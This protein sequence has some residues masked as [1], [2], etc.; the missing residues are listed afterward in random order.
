MYLV[1][2]LLSRAAVPVQSY[3]T[4]LR[5]NARAA[6]STARAKSQ[7]RS[8]PNNDENTEKTCA[9]SKS[10]GFA[11]AFEGSF[12]TVNDKRTSQFIADF[13]QSPRDLGP[14]C[15]TLG[16][17]SSFLGAVR[18]SV[19][20]SRCHIILTDHARRNHVPHASRCQSRI[21][22]PLPPTPYLL[23]AFCSA[24]RPVFYP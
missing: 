16:E 22:F 19:L 20:I 9:K 17:W 12:P 23:A 10:I 3:L 11:V 14:Y 2:L 1:K 24:I 21:L 15:P 4:W 13:W 8:P 7:S 18:L 5:G 6:A